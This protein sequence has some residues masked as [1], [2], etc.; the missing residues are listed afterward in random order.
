MIVFFDTSVLVAASVAS[1]PHHRSAA[2]A[3][4]N[5][6]RKTHRGWISQ[7]GVAEVYA[8]LTSL[9]VSPRIHP[10]DALRIIEGLLQH[11]HVAELEP[12]D[13]V[14]VLKEVAAR[15]WISGR[16]YDALHVY[17]AR[18]VDCRCLYTLNLKDF[19][20]VASEDFTNRIQPPPA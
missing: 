5:V 13:Y 10:A 1:H 8:A 16:V 6:R 19:R 2:A 14:A 9:P 7:H 17:C 4:E 18:K 20:A 3:I 11:F 15:N 12:S